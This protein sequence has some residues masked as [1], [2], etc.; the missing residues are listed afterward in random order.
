LDRES[1]V[2]AT[3]FEM[4][5]LLLVNVVPAVV[6]VNLERDLGVIGYIRGRSYRTVIDKCVDY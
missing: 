5:D 4:I 1:F 2:T 3:A 6:G